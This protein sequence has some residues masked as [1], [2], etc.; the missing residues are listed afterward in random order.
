MLP[1]KFRDL[2]IWTPGEETPSLSG[3][4]RHRLK[5]ASEMVRYQS[6]LP[7]FDE[8]NI[9]LHPLDTDVTFGAYISG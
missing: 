4:E 5:L 8:P 1:G 7:V 3:G 9:G 6:I 2:V